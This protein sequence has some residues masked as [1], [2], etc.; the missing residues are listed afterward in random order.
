MFYFDYIRDEKMTLKKPKVLKSEFFDDKYLLKLE[1]VLERDEIRK[2]DEMESV[3]E[4]FENI[5][6]LYRVVKKVFKNEAVIRVKD[7]GGFI[8]APMGSTSDTEG[9]KM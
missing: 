3:L 4:F 8:F 1:K 7:G 6:S 5:E 9:I 2:R